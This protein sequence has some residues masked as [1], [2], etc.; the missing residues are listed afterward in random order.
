MRQTTIGIL[1]TVFLLLPAVSAAGPLKGRTNIHTGFWATHDCSM[2]SYLDG[3][4][5]KLPPRGGM[6]HINA[7]LP[8]TETIDTCKAALK[9][10]GVCKIGDVVVVDAT[11]MVKQYG[12][13]DRDPKVDENGKETKAHRVSNALLN[14]VINKPLKVWPDYAK[15]VQTAVFFTAFKQTSTNNPPGK[16]GGCPLAWHSEFYNKAGQVMNI[17]GI[18][19]PY[20][21][22]TPGQALHAF[23]NMWSIK[24]WTDEE[25]KNQDGVEPLNILAHETQHDVC[26]FIQHMEEKNGTQVVSKKLIGHQGAHW[27]LYH[28]TYGQLMYGCNWRD[29]G[30]GTFYSIKPARGTRPLDLYLWGLV[31]ASAVKPVFI[32]DTKSKK[33]TPKQKTLDA[34]KKDCGSSAKLDDFDFC[35]DPPY[36]RTISGSCG[37]YNDSVVQTPTR[38]RATGTKKWVTMKNITDAIGKRVPDYKTAYKY[39]T[40]LFVLVI[41]GNADLV[42]KDLDRLE[43]FRR[44]F[45]R[46]LYSVTGYRL[47]NINTTDNVDDSPFWEWGGAPDWSGVEELEGWAGKNLAKDLTLKRTAEEGKLVLHLKDKTSGMVNAKM[48]VKPGLYNGFSVKMTVPLPKDGKRKLVYGKFVM[49][50]TAGKVELKLPVYADGKEHV[51]AVHPPHKLMKE[52]T[53]KQ[54]C[55]ALCKYE[56]KPNEGWYNSCTDKLIVK[57]KCKDDK[58]VNKCGPYCTGPKTDPMLKASDKQGWYDSCKTTLSGSYTS[59]TLIPV[60]DA[61]AGKLSGPVLVDA[62]DFMVVADQVKDTAKKKDGEKDWDGDGLINAFDNCPLV[63]NSNQQDSN[64]DEKGDAC[65]DFDA[66]GV[67]NALDNCPA[68]VNSLQQDDDG[69]GEGN[70]CDDD[71]EEGCSVPPGVPGAGGALLVLGLVLLVALRRRSR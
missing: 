68:V 47:R 1:V 15:S 26:C 55:T 51:I 57:I 7:P 18:G 6:Q 71:Y 34:I 69:D 30:N 39:N 25:W 4:Q 61:V 40:Q 31:P 66:D 16:A 59:L 10:D 63:A 33:C 44:D 48:R 29:E 38:I 35:L 24:D 58:G 60:D 65:D 46:Q 62:I 21:P 14:A 27:S 12:R 41:G 2:P 19:K 43:G 52:Q 67:A 45:N 42:Q 8:A 54:G 36:Y 37:V 11:G 23:V 64:D 56:N 5:V 3:K 20:N 70:A 9:S 22:G 17:Q 49:A 13:C 32:V 28:N 50:G 53:C